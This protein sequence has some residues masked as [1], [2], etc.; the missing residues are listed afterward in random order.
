M[1]TC[2]MQPYG[3]VAGHLPSLCRGYSVEAGQ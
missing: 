2:R 1:V 3:L